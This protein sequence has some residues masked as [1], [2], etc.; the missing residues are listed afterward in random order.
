MKL[1][2]KRKPEWV[3]LD[4]GYLH[5]LEYYN[6]RI[7]IEGGEDSVTWCIIPGWWESGLGYLRGGRDGER[8]L[9]DIKRMAEKDLKGYLSAKHAAAKQ[10]VSYWERIE[11]EAMGN[12]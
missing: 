4:D 9:N 11:E 8:T 2:F 12:G 1:S 7:K 10:L 6:G 5:V 3:T